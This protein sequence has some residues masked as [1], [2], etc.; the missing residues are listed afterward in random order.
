MDSYASTGTVVGRGLDTM[1]RLNVAETKKDSSAR[2]INRYHGTPET[3]AGI[4]TPSG[5][6]P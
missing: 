2:K 6:K 3:E 5:Y 1:G 4:M